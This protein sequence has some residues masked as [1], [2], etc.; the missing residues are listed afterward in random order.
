MGAYSPSR[1][2]NNELE[3]K[4]INKIIKPTIN[5]LAELGTQYK[6]FLY[7]GLMIVGNEPFLI[8][9]NVRM[10][11][12]ECQTI[13][14]K[15]KTNLIDIIVACCDGKLN[16]IKINWSEKKSLCV[17]V[18]AKGYPDKFRK[19]IE[20]ENIK[21]IKLSNNEYLFHAGTSMKNKK[22]YA[23]GG[24]VLNFVS[25][26]HDFNI[27]RKNIIKNLNELNWV[28]GFYRK[29]IGHKVIK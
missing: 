19:N 4:I 28:G 6:G 25:L 24:R 14:P 21:K 10:G 11:D 12:P 15:L 16:E 22:V 3:K 5:G 27:S 29:D 9:Y 1:L 8:E 18:C 20:I 7:A 17:V 2:I 13:L 23:I 26:S